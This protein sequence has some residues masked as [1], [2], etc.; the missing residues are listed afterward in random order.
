[1]DDMKC[2]IEIQNDERIATTQPL[3]CVASATDDARPY[4]TLI[5]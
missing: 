2:S 1:M 3:P 5:K 4:Q